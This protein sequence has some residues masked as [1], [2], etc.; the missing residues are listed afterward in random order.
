MGVPV[1]E[2][3]RTQDIFEHVEDISEEIGAWDID[4]YVDKDHG[5][6]KNYSDKNSSIK[7]MSI[8]VKVTK[9]QHSIIIY[10]LK[11]NIKDNMK[12]HAELIKKQSLL[13][14]LVVY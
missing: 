6:G 3:K 4:E 8:I 5:V 10:R 13:N 1:K 9:F 12:A 11:K 2:K 7:W 14:Q